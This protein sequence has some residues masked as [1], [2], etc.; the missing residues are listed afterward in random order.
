M[1]IFYSYARKCVHCVCVTFVALIIINVHLIHTVKTIQC[2]ILDL[3]IH[4]VS[5]VLLF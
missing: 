5:V 1:F 2:F 4:S 3:I